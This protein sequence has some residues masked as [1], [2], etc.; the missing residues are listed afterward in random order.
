MKKLLA[1][2]LLAVVAFQAP[3][4]SLSD[5]GVRIDQITGKFQGFG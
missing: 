2:L 5:V 1:L 3:A 4:Q